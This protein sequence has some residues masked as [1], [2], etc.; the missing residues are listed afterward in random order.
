M[1]DLARVYSD[2]AGE[3]D[4]QELSGHA[5]QPS[6]IDGS[7]ASPCAPKPTPSCDAHAQRV[8]RRRRRQGAGGAG[9]RAP[10]GALIC[11]KG[12]VYR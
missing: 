9:R 2:I 11:Q 12:A 7:G 1:A 8:L 10:R 4:Q 3:L 6:P 5:P